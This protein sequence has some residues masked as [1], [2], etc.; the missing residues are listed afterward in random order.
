MNLLIFVQLAQSQ[1]LSKFGAGKPQR[2][3]THG[4]ISSDTDSDTKRP[5]WGGG[6]RWRYSSGV[7][8]GPLPLAPSPEEGGGTRAFVAIWLSGRIV[9]LAL[10]ASGRVA[11]RP[12]GGRPASELAHPLRTCS[13]WDSEQVRSPFEQVWEMGS[14]VAVTSRHFPG[15]LH[16]GLAS[17]FCLICRTC[18]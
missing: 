15:V 17:L 12:G 6:L 18:H 2:N 16:T 5:P 11:D 10:P 13:S 14:D 3:V 9:T 1:T 4:N 7:G 8:G